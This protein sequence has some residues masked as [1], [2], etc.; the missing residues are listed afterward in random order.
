MANTLPHHPAGDTVLSV[1]WVVLG[2][3]I[4]RSHPVDFISGW[5]GCSPTSPAL[6]LPVFRSPKPLLFPDSLYLTCSALR[7][8]TCS[9][10]AC[11][12][13]GESCSSH[14]SPYP[15]VCVMKVKNVMGTAVVVVMLAVVLSVGSSS[16]CSSFKS[17]PC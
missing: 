11:Y 4:W 16:Y 8:S 15:I 5:Q 2:G 1:P 7:P 13:W 12:H 3:Y 17:S 9:L 10:V 6:N 14:R